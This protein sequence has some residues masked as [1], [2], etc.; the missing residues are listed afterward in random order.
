MRFSIKLVLSYS[1]THPTSSSG[2]RVRNLYKHSLKTEGWTVLTANLR[3]FEDDEVIQID[4]VLTSSIPIISQSKSRVKQRLK[5]VVSYFL[6][7]DRSI[8]WSI[9]ATLYVLKIT[10]NMTDEKPVR[11][12]GVGYPFSNLLAGAIIK[13]FRKKKCFYIAHF[14]DGFYLINKGNDTS[15]IFQ[16][17]NY[18]AERFI[19]SI[20]DKVIVNKCKEEDFKKVFPSYLEKVVFVNE[21][22][23]RII[24]VENLENFEK[25]RY[26]FAGSL[27]KKIR[28]PSKVIDYFF[29]TKNIFIM[30]GNI[31]DCQSALH[32]INSS[33]IQ[34]L[35]MLSHNELMEQYSRAEFLVNI[36]N[37]DS[38]QQP[39]GKII[40]Y[41]SL[42]KPIINFYKGRSISGKVLKTS[43]LRVDSYLE[44]NIEDKVEENIKKICDFKPL[45]KGE[46]FRLEDTYEQLGNIYNEKP[47]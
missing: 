6:W 2:R 20:S 33:K 10:R 26:F 30:A 17:L 28:E 4:D 15:F 18:L 46:I 7:P 27:Y 22:A 14:I 44:I 16:P 45:I 1:F 21:T 40:E 37:Q 43:A 3:K 41:M 47:Y 29:R 36:D 35:G 42:Q 32:D 34:H 31:N 38:D 39:P 19:I 23:G 24:N 8:L 12:V 13:W 5:K 11:V 25:N 9:K